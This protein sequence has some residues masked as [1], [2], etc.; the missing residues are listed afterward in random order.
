M[1]AATTA[2]LFAQD[3][4]RVH[5]ARV[6]G[7]QGALRHLAA[8]VGRAH[9]YPSYATLVHDKGSVIR[10]YKILIHGGFV[11]LEPRDRG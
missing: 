7:T 11:G 6:R 10:R 1:A 2:T 9:W 5:M 3:H 8:Y 4:R